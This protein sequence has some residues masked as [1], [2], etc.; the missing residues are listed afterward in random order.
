MI[1]PTIQPK[2]LY[3]QIAD[4]LA[5]HIRN[6][7]FPAGSYLPSERDLA[8][9]LGVSRSS[10]R[11]ALI[12]LEVSGLVEIRVGNGVYVCDQ[13]E[14][15]VDSDQ[16]AESPFALLEARSLFESEIAG[17]A[18]QK[19]T[20]EQIAEI[21]K[22]I[23]AMAGSLPD[24]NAYLEQDHLFHR[25]IAEATGN[26]IMVQ[27]VEHLWELRRSSLFHKFEEHYTDMALKGA[28]IDDHSEILEAIKAG[29]AR[30]AR[31]AMKAHMSHV[32]NRF[33]K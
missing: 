1:L 14:P 10:V 27:L 7:E 25:Y 26:D 13:S 20:P 33:S 31:A 4:L 30:K 12:A 21:E 32:K 11:E 15:A 8:K 22:T 3:R 24:H 16:S 17:L 29:D 28:T 19:A 18:A 9:Q 6:G 23:S 2:R 5:N